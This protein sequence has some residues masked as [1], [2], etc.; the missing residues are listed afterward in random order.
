M[1]PFALQS[2]EWLI[3][4]ES[5]QSM[6]A[7]AESAAR[8]PGNLQGSPRESPLISVSS[9]VATVDICGPIMRNPDAFDRIMNGATD[10]EEIHAALQQAGERPDVHSVFLNIDSPGGTVIGTPELAAAV[11]ALNEKKPVC[12]FSSGLMASAAYWIASQASAIYATPSAR[13]GS[14]GVIQTVM[15]QSAR[16]AAAGIK[17]EVFTAGKFKAMGHPATSLTDS[18]REHIQANLSEIAADFHAAVLAKGR[19]VPAEA[20]EGQTFSGRQAEKVQ[21]ATMVPNRAEAMRRLSVYGSAVDTRS[22][23]M[24]AIEDQLATANADLAKAQADL[25]ANADLLT[26]AS[27][28]LDSAKADHAKVLGERSAIQAQLDSANAELATF[29]SRVTALEAS[30]ADFDKKVQTELA[31]LAAST[32]TQ[33]PANVTGSQGNGEAK[34]VTREELNAMDPAAITAFIK[35]GGKII[36]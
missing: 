10:S 18:Q 11:S 1:N 16:L 14:I 4:P 36:D 13:V 17:V 35:S 32:G 33:T 29:K 31:R 24:K 34:V 7:A 26:E 27:T 2:R 28:N 19:K 5:L 21:L 12:A 6:I 20:M 8:V 23:A 15:D 30:Q 3:L 9:G 25:K 22:R